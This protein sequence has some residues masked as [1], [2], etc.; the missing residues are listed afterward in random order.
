MAVNG[1][2]LRIENGYKTVMCDAEWMS[3]WQKVK[4]DDKRKKCFNDD[5][6]LKSSFRT[7]NGIICKDNV[8][9]INSHP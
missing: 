1:Y 2:V 4:W 7:E 9:D 5:T 3:F 8:L 6:W